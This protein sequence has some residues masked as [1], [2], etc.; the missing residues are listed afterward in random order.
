MLSVVFSSDPPP[1]EMWP[2]KW[3]IDSWYHHLVI[4][5]LRSR[6]L[7]CLHAHRVSVWKYSCKLWLLLILLLTLMIEPENSCYP[8]FLFRLE[9]IYSSQLHLNTDKC[10]YWNTNNYITR[11]NNHSHLYC[12]R[13]R[14]TKN[15]TSVLGSRGMFRSNSVSGLWAKLGAI[16]CA[17]RKVN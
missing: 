13:I 4:S 17:G 10:K 15:K 3:D 16:L 11:C 6:S 14:K 5:V 7:N 8:N 1:L 12:M 2:S 9:I